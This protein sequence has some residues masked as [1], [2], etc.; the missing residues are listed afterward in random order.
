MSFTAQSNISNNK[1]SQVKCEN[2]RVSYG[3][4]VHR[5]ACPHVVS[6]K[7]ANLHCVRSVVCLCTGREQQTPD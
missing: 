7:T 1:E 2:D 3:N 5:G 6:Y 4:M